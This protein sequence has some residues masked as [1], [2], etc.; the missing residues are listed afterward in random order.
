MTNGELPTPPPSAED[1]ELRKKAERLVEE[2]VGLYWHMAVY[3]LINGM[4][5]M[6]WAL[7]GHPSNIWPIWVTA[8]WGIGL[9][10]HIMG[11][12]LGRRGEGRRDAMVRKEMERLKKEKERSG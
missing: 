3:T 8:F 2:K 6:V 7:S 10:F 11:Y 1:E 12:L 4:L 9:L 5:W